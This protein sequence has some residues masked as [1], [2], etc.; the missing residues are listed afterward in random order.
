MASVV[1][2]TKKQ[3]TVLTKIGRCLRG[4]IDGK[5]VYRYVRETPRTTGTKSNSL[6]AWI[7]DGFYSRNLLDE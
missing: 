6:T 5:A 3:M 1:G 2:K 7:E 4:L